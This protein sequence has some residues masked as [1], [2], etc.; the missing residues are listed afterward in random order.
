MANIHAIVL[1]RS[2]RQSLHIG[3]IRAK[4]RERQRTWRP[5]ITLDARGGELGQ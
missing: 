3:R 2:A 4:Q 1:A 5:S